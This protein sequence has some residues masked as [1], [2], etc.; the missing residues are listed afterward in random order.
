AQTRRSLS[1][2]RAEGAHEHRAA[3]AGSSKREHSTG[4]TLSERLVVCARSEHNDEGDL[5]EM[6]RALKARGAKKDNDLTA[7]LY[8]S[9]FLASFGINPDGIERLEHMRRKMQENIEKIWIENWL[10]AW[11]RKRHAVRG[12]L[13]FDDIFFGRSH[14]SYQFIDLLSG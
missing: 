9:P 3:A 2:T 13:L 10:A 1:L 11:Q 14:N 4:R 12:S 7:R 6:V 5:P 8:E